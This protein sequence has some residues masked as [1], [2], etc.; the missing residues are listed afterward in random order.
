ML[1]N[2]RCGPELPCVNIENKS[3]FLLTWKQFA[4]LDQTCKNLNLKETCFEPGERQKEKCSTAHKAV[5]RHTDGNAEANQ[6]ERDH[7]KTRTQR[8]DLLQK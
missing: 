3:G 2:F 1:L 7:T 5:I 6:S 8:A 4:T